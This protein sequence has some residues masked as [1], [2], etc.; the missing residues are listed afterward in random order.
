MKTIIAITLLAGICVAQDVQVVTRTNYLSKITYD[1]AGNRQV[2]RV[3]IIQQVPQPL[4]AANAAELETVLNQ[5]ATNKTYAASF[6][7]VIGGTNAAPTY[8]VN[9]RIK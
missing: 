2:E 1:A 8:K 9:I 4:T 7:M 6:I 5:L 3:P